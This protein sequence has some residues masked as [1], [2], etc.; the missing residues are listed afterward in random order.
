MRGQSQVIVRRQVDDALAVK[1]AD[2]LLLVLE[3]AQFE[4]GALFLQ[5]VELLGEIGSLWARSGGGHKQKIIAG[6]GL[7]FTVYGQNQNQPQRN[8]GHREAQRLPRAVHYESNQAIPARSF[9]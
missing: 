1:G 9:Q 5:V 4:I 6:T 8:R 3:D 7:W 2:R